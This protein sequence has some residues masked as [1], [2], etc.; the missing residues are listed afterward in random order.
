MLRV[1]GWKEGRGRRECVRACVR[2]SGWGAGRQMLVALSTPSGAQ[3]CLIHPRSPQCGGLGMTR[4]GGQSGVKVGGEAASA[5]QGLP[6]PGSSVPSRVRLRGQGQAPSPPPVGVPEDE[7]TSS[8]SDWAKWAGLPI[9]TA[10][11]LH[12]AGRAAGGAGRPGCREARGCGESP[13][14]SHELLS[15]LADCALSTVPPACPA[16]LSCPKLGDSGSRCHHE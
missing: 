11:T 9:P 10:S 1:V 3:G 4:G 16:A 15:C 6:R 13:S 2:V 12:S 7:A 14:S 8:S 5:Q